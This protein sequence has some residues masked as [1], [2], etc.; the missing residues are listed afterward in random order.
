MIKYKYEVTGSRLCGE[1]RVSGSKNAVLPIL[2]ATLINKSVSYIDNCPALSDLDVAVEILESFGCSVFRSCQCIVVDASHATYHKVPPGLAARCR[3]SL[4]FSGSSYARFGLAEL[5]S[6][7]G[8]VLGPRPVDMH[9]DMMR[10]LGLEVKGLD[11]VSVQGNILDSDITLPYPSVGVTENVMMMAARGHAC[12]CIRNAA[13]EPE[14]VNLAAY[15]SALG[16]GISGVGT[17]HIVVRGCGECCREVRVRV[18]PDRIEAATF[19]LAG[20]M[21]GRNVMVR[22]CF[23]CHFRKLSSLLYNM[24]CDLDIG[25]DYVTMRRGLLCR[26]LKPPVCVVA[27][28]FP[29]FPTDMQP[30]IMPLLCMITSEKSQCVVTDT[31]FP[32]RF[33]LC[34]ELEK[35]GARFH[36]LRGS[37][38]LEGLKYKSFVAAKNLFSH[39]LR[40]GAALVLAGLACEEGS[41]C[42]IF[43]GGFIERGYENIAE[44]F[45]QIG[46][47]VVV[48]LIQ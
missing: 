44:K 5:A 11:S 6:P 20:A 16:V 10:L 19:L 45:S 18:I 9:I 40:G 39:D 28:P 33:A 30:L 23:P 21:S 24:G 42:D 7:G 15:L 1:V 48:K 13:R 31:V 2:A 29:C 43:D 14:I 41:V 34:G 8:C 3:A 36:M 26:P 37:C 38:V 4:A 46:G 22:D 25:T 12:V 17:S 32:A 27:K 35:M 47:K